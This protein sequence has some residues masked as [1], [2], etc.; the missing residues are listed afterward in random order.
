MAK[1]VSM[2]NWKGGVGKTTAT[3]NIGAGLAE[4]SDFEGS[5]VLLV[6]LDPQTNLSYSVMGV[7]NYVKWAYKEGRPTLKNLYED[8][9]SNKDH[10]NVDEALV[11]DCIGSSKNID[12]LP[13]HLE[14]I[15]IDMKLAKKKEGVAELEQIAGEELNRLSILLNLFKQVENDYDYIICDCPPNFNLVTQNAIFAS[16]AF[17]I[18][19]LPDFLSTI[20]MQ[21][22][23]QEVSK[24]NKRVKQYIDLYDPSIEYKNTDLK[25]ILFTRVK[26]YRGRPKE[27]H[28][29]TITRIENEFPGKVFGG[30]SLYITDGDGLVKASNEFRS[31]YDH[32][33]RYKDTVSMKQAD[34]YKECTLDFYTRTQGDSDD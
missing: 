11:K 29:E 25:G 20:G 17:F 4:F 32:A 19:A 15:F 30:G 33:S 12:L 2:I 23:V 26:E 22:I 7:D 27:S 14:L 6:D 31:I 5:R 21:Q 18:P 3:L 8:Y 28:Y 13:S 10:F 1:I 9:L 24:L 34:Q 16:E